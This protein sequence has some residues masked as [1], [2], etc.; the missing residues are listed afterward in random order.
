M[1]LLIE[2]AKRGLERLAIANDHFRQRLLVTPAFDS[3]ETGPAQAGQANDSRAAHAVKMRIFTVS[4]A[5]DRFRAA[6]GATA[7][8]PI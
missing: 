2:S 1:D 7:A 4:P 6:S 8:G 3:K 5:A